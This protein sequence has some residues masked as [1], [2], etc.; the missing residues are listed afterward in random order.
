MGIAALL[1]ILLFTSNCTKSSMDN[2][3][4]MGNQM[5]TGTGSG[6]GANEVLIQSMSFIPSTLTI[7]AG[8]TV[9]WT[10][11]D[12]ITHT[13]TSNTKTFNSGNVTSNST[14]SFTF[15]TA[16]T[17]SYYCSIHPSMMGTIVV[18]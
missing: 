4:N 9:K 18:K 13:V 5:S 14:F 15:N 7:A 11:K 16:G 12:P 8:T 6:P 3:M 1:A 2:S 10:N 17:Y